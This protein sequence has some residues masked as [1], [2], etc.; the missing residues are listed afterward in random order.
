M[1]SSLAS[2][3]EGDRVLR[4]SINIPLC[5]DFFSLHLLCIC[6]D[7]AITEMH[8]DSSIIAIRTKCAEQQYYTQHNVIVVDGNCSI[9]IVVLYD[10]CSTSYNSNLQLSVPQAK[11][12][13]PLQYLR[14]SDLNGQ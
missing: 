2:W 1:E 5:W 7:H 10:Y 4:F 11:L 9:V 14:S 13:W 6:S 12:V 3:R 8:S